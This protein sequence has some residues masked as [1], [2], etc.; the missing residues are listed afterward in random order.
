MLQCVLQYILTHLLLLIAQLIMLSR[1]LPS[2]IPGNPSYQWKGF[3]QIASYVQRKDVLLFWCCFSLSDSVLWSCPG[4]CQTCNQSKE[5][6]CRWSDNKLSFNPFCFEALPRS[7]QQTPL[8]SKQKKGA[9]GR[10]QGRQFV[11]IASSTKWQGT[12]ASSLQATKPYFAC[13][14]KIR[15][16]SIYG[17]ILSRQADKLYWWR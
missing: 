12:P 2:R 16:Q 6:W 15:C 1:D 9:S 10:G 7:S 4:V 17:P 11:L 14:L 13:N 3:E 8:G 5:G